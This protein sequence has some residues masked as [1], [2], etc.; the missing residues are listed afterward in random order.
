MNMTRK[1]PIAVGL[2]LSVVLL[3]AMLWMLKPAV[4]S[5]RKPASELQP[6]RYQII[7]VMD[8]KKNFIAVVLDTQSGDVYGVAIESGLTL[9]A[10]LDS[11]KWTGPGR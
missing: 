11:H 4:A 6:E 9:K 7:S 8:P 10:G 2:S 1:G 5:A 3:L